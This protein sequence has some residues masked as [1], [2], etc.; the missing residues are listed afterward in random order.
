MR[1]VLQDTLEKL[2]ASQTRMELAESI[3]GLRDLLEVEHIVYHAVNHEGQQYVAASY[4]HAWQSF[5][6]RENLTRIDPVVLAGHSAYRPINWNTLDWSSKQ[7]RKMMFDATD[8][9]VGNQGLSLPIHGPNGQFAILTISQC[10]TDAAWDSTI[11]RIGEDL[12]YLSHAINSKA[13]LLHGSEASGPVANLSPR[14]VAALTRLASGMNRAQA[15]EALGISEHTL[16]V[17]VEGARLK[18]GAQNTIHAVARAISFG[19]IAI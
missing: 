11:R 15:A 9:G 17:Y 12:V 5:Y 14:E 6:E 19:L 1:P 4:S 18:L 16:R 8:A 13:L 7:A 3:L 10:D 2:D